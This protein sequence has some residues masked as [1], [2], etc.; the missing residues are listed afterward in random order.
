MEAVRHF[1]YGVM[2]NITFTSYPVTEE[3]RHGCGGSIYKKTY[4]GVAVGELHIGEE[5]KS[6]KSAKNL[7]FGNN[8]F[9]DYKEQVILKAKQLAMTPDRRALYWE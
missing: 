2:K 6:M 3:R 5:A 7:K 9:L 4:V 8:G 1:D